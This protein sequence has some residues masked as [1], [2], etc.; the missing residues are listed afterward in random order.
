MIYNK[1]ASEARNL[2]IKSSH[3]HPE[4]QRCDFNSRF[5][6]DEYTGACLNYLTLNLMTTNPHTGLKLSGHEYCVGVSMHRV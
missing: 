6:S 2:I 4:G 5:D 3:H 1:P